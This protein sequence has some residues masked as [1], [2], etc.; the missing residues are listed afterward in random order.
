MSHEACQPAAETVAAVRRILHCASTIGLLATMSLGATV[1]VAQQAPN[2]PAA[3]TEDTG[4]LPEVVVTAQFRSENL[5]STPISITAITADDLKQQQLQNVN[6]LG[7]SVPNAYFRA[8]TSNYGPTESIGLRGFTQIDAS[9]GFQPTVGFYIDDVYQGTLLGSSFDLADMERVEVLN[10]PQGTLFGMNSIGGA[11]RLITQKPKDE[12]E[13]NVQLT[14]GEKHRMEFVGVFNTP[15]ID[16][17]L[18]M[19]VVGVSR[20]E[21]SIG[22]NLDYT[23][24]MKAEGQ[25]VSTYGTLPQSAS[26]NNCALGG[27]GGFNHQNARVELR[28]TPITDLEVNVTGFYTKQDDDPT[29]NTLLSPYGGPTDTFNNNYN[30]KVVFPMYGMNLTNN[31]HLLSPNPWDNFAGY[32][33]IVT[34]QQQQEKT[35]LQQEG[36]T[37]TLD[38][39][40][41]GAIQLKYIWG[42]RTY[43]DNWSNDSDLTP[44]AL[45]QTTDFEFHRQFQNEIRLSG[46][47]FDDHLNWTVGGFDYNQ[48]E[49]SVAGTDWQAEQLLGVQNNNTTAGF[50]TNNISGFIHLEFRFNQQWSVSGGWRLTSQTLTYAYA[51]IVDNPALQAADD[52]VLPEPLEFSG[53]HGDW[54]GTVNYQ[55]THNLFFYLQAASGFT[56]P[57]FSSRVQTIGQLAERVPGQSADNYEIGAKTDWLDHRL[58]VNGSLFYEDYKSYLNLQIASQCTNA[59]SLDPG[60][61]NYAATCPAGTPRA[62]LAGLGPWFVYSGL[63]AYEP[64]AELQINAEPIDR[65]V[66]NL[67]GG[68]LE[69]HSKLDNPLAPGY[70]APSVRLQPEFNASGGIQYGVLVPGGS[71]TPRLDWHYQGYQTNGPQKYYQI[72][73]WREP[74]Y[75]VFNARLTY[76]PTAGKWNVSLEALNVFNKFYWDQLGAPSSVAAGATVPSANNLIPAVG[77]VGT[78]GLPRE[79]MVSFG[80]NF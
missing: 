63:P 45:I 68:W 1:V 65:L 67:E 21:D 17:V 54:S 27:L 80:M 70:I 42:Y 43:T 58:R 19:R 31:P 56:L 11:I 57:G 40:L 44:F 55:A 23:C 18:D 75:S 49:T 46:D 61:P 72:T 39:K 29:L 30:A 60:T 28:Y 7:T 51:H 69:F 48:R 5:Q 10:G 62:G 74:G 15:L 8:P 9:Y 76:A 13:A 35:T 6:D 79:W 78:P 3:E 71:I 12:T 14:Y 25:P 26:Q 47:A 66:M 52:I 64:G 4:T 36:V 24:T 38:Y 34:G 41:P 37:A 73:Q 16:H 77:R 33:D 59:N 2:S 32:G 53:S 22:H 50:T 20:S